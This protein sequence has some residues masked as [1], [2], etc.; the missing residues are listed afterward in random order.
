MKSFY[1][2][3]S[4]L[5]SILM[6]TYCGEF[7]KKGT[8]TD[9]KVSQYITAYKN[10]KSKT[11]GL[12]EK[13]NQNGESVQAGKEGFADFESAIKESGL[14]GYSEFVVLNA[15]I[16]SIFGII[17]ASKGMNQ[18]EN[19]H[20]QGQEMFSEAQQTIQ[21]QL[22][23][24]NVSEETK[25]ELRKSLEEIKNSQK[26]VNA[27]YENNMKWGKFVMEKVQKISGLIVDEKDI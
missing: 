11:P 25:N 10:L 6:F 21:K 12:L 4:L 16:G 14:S 24:P 23:D 18:F 22:D 17:Q 15:K 3:I 19:M 7:T 5:S 26:T 9:E 1:V 2:I 27:D 20:N 13:F 8:L